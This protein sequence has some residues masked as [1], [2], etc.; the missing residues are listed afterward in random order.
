MVQG[1]SGF[2]II[3]PVHAIQNRC[4]AVVVSCLR[5]LISEVTLMGGL[6]MSVR[7]SDIDPS[8]VPNIQIAANSIK[9]S[10]L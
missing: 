5:L 7:E 6:L 4:W 3:A 1:A 10:S 2:S 9:S 8:A